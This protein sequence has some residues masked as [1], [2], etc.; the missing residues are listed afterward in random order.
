[1]K[2]DLMKKILA[3]AAALFMAACSSESNGF[4]A[5]DVCPESGTNA[6]GMPNRGI[7]T[8]DR[9][10][11]VYKYT[12]IGDQVWMAQNLNYASENSVC[13]NN[14]PANCEIYG[15]LY[16]L[17][18][19]EK[20]KENGRI[21]YNLADSVCPSGWHVPSNQEWLK[22]VNTV[23]DLNDKATATRLKAT[24]LWN[25]DQKNGT[26]ECGFSAIPGGYTNTREIDGK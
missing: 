26:D 17:L 16:L 7:F 20:G 5:G 6:Y 9:D 4:S 23:G 25:E 10:G 24:N 22:M 12:T 13:Y 2:K 19:R 18:S 15:R 21:N 1:M 14:D 8:D 3:S 11:Q